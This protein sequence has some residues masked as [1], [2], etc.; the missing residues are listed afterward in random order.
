MMSLRAILGLL[1]LVLGLGAV[2]WFT[3]EKPPV[4]KVAE[5]HVLQGR[6]LGECKRMRW[7]LQDRAP[8]EVVR[9]ADGRYRLEE[10]LVDLASAAH[11][12]QIAVA[13]DSAQMRATPLQD[14]DDGRN[15]AGLVPPEL[16]F[17]V[18]FADAEPLRIEVG[19]P[20]P[21]GTTRFLRMHGKIWEGGEALLESM[22]VGLDDL[23]ERSVFRNTVD[24]TGELRVEQLLPTGKREALHVKLEKD[25]WRLLE[26]I[27]G[28]ADP[29]AAQKFV[30]AVLGLRIDEFLPGVVKPRETPP[31]LRI[32]VKGAHGEEKLD[33]W[34]ENLELYGR[35]EDRK[36]WFQSSSNQYSQIFENATEQLRARI[37]M[38][39]G[40]EAFNGLVELIADPGQGNGD[41]LRL[42]RQTP[43]EAWFLVEPVQ[44]AT[45]PIACNEALHALQ[46]MVAIEFVEDADARRPRADDPRYGLQPG[47][48]FAVTTR[49]ARDKATTT[50]WLG[51]ETKRGDVTYVHACRADE[52]DA[53]VLVPATMAATLRRSWLEYI[54]LRVHRETAAVEKIELRRGDGQSRTFELRDGKW[55]QV[56]VAGAR[57]EVGELVREELCDLVAARALDARGPT[58]ATPDWTLRMMRLN[59]DGLGELRFFDR[60]A[61]GPLLVQRG[62]GGAIAFELKPR[63]TKDLRALWQ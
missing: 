32:A 14:D 19:A 12:R 5:T 34:D 60:G 54:S 62:D 26:P 23:R 16:V 6:S 46:R 17:T 20:G 45:A 39:I 63:L 57:D 11:L 43:D 58:F 56:G 22:R 28:R 3:D 42:S 41:R 47:A 31:R 15:K 36:I 35:S 52:P 48:R 59:G 40:D 18:E 49:T 38:P 61:D 33:L 37:L 30:T 55:G 13:W 27:T 2:L 50:L 10:P 25:G 21:L 53:V 9:G 51:S 8:I 7:Q 29:V 44:Q 1:A 24:A 4:V